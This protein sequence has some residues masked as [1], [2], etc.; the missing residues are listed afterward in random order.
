M[1]MATQD[2]S[3]RSAAR[4]RRAAQVTGKAALKSGGAT[5]AQAQ[6]AAQP[7]RAPAP[8]PAPAPVRAPS[9]T[10]TSG[11]IGRE[12][13]RARRAALAGA[14]KAAIRSPE[15][16]RSD[17][18]EAPA[19]GAPMPA[20]MGA[21]DEPMAAADPA[22]APAAPR[23]VTPKA[24]PSKAAEA[25]AG[26]MLSKARRRAISS[27]GKKGQDALRNGATAA[28]M[29][30]HVDPDISGRD[31]SRKVREERSRNGRTCSTGKAAPTGR[32]RPT[33]PA[34]PSEG[35]TGTQ[36]A[37]G[38]RTTGGEVGLCHDI[39]G[40]RYL[41]GATFEAFCSTEPPRAPRKVSAMRTLHGG[42][43]TG[44][45]VAALETRVTGTEPGRCR[46]VTGDEYLGGE[47]YAAV[48]DVV[49]SPEPAKVTRSRTS[50]GH[51]VSGA[52][53]GAEGGAAVTGIEAGRTR[54]ITGT[55]Y[56]GAEETPNAPRPLERP[57]GQ[58]ADITGLQPG[59]GRLTGA[60][61]GACGPITGTPYMGSAHVA[62]VCGVSGAARPTDP[63]YPRPLAGG[64]L[65]APS[66]TRTPTGGGITG[67]RYEQGRV[68]GTFSLGQGKVT[69][70]EEFRFD[71]APSAPITRPAGARPAMAMQRAAMAAPAQ[72]PAPAVT[73]DDQLAAP[74]PTAPVETP[75]APEPAPRITGEG[76]DRGLR[77]TGDDWD[78]GDRV[79]GTEGFSAAGRNPTQ[80]GRPSVMETAR[81]RR[82]EPL[83]PKDSPVTGSSGNSERGAV[84]T[85]SGG[86][87]G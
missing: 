23:K 86:A 62:E 31:L 44:T 8:R 63:D 24:A 3:G 33:R 78:R 36:V 68:S 7:A 54:A 69:G 83:P 16:T 43:V 57:A 47:H 67:T 85:V 5:R 81:D 14:G 39:T 18:P 65:S 79:T 73:G 37:P 60:Q 1:T 34:G 58:G 19:K 22:P 21:H 53:T 6:A 50:R 66:P 52:W 70:T 35:T 10:A 4:A 56:A 46:A 74:A 28:Q 64:T 25:S 13:S 26:R 76:M 59:F 32:A 40:T 9:G 71:R 75:M 38:R 55:P 77:I 27:A 41:S 12:A 80:R 15:R 48:C 45:S 17:A 84:V 42:G 49:P 11:S 72:A 61:K 2:L 82:A 20:A 30:R 87:R 51:A 29:A